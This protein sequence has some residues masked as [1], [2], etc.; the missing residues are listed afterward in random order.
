MRS[1]EGLQPIE[2]RLEDIELD[3]SQPYLCLEL[4]KQIVAETTTVLDTDF[5][6]DKHF[7]FVRLPIGEYDE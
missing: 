3:Y 5:A 7:V 6:P 4:L 1:L 2:A